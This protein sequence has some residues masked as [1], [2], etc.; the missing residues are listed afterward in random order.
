MSPVEIVPEMWRW[1]DGSLD[2]MSVMLH[3]PGGG[4]RPG[5]RIPA[6][7][8]LCED[9]AI[10]RRLLVHEFLHCF[11]SVATI[12][13][14][15]EKNPGERISIGER[16]DPLN[17]A[18]HDARLADPFDW[19]GERDAEL[20]PRDQDRDSA[21]FNPIT[22]TMARYMAHFRPVYP[23]LTISVHGGALNLEGSAVERARELSA[24]R[25]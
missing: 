1:K 8:A 20:L 14:A 18:E 17:P 13:A 4:F 25:K 10:V 7:V 15:I 3:I 11:H 16:F 2:G 6:Q 23:D 5:A 12:L 21:V 22:K 24:S 19:F 9:D